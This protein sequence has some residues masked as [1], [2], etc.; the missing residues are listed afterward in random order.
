[1]TTRGGD[2]IEMEA[3]QLAVSLRS[4]KSVHRTP[5]VRIGKEKGR[6]S[7]KHQ[8]QGKENPQKGSGEV[9]TFVLTLSR[10]ARHASNRRGQLSV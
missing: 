7:V 4:M 1:V 5:D 9:V 3:P 2:R 8:F 6:I 10:G